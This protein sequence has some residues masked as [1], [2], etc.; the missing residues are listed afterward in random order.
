MKRISWRSWVTSLRWCDPELDGE[1]EHGGH[2][3][4]ISTNL[5]K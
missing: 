2:E 4:G 1:R 5:Y 3:R